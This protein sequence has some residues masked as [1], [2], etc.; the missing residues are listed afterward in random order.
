MNKSKRIKVLQPDG[1]GAAVLEA[2][3]VLT[4]D[5]DCDCQPA[6]PA[7][8]ERVVPSTAAIWKRD[9]R[10]TGLWSKNEAANSW[11]AIRGIGWKKLANTSDSGNI[12]L[13]VLATQA[14]QTG[15]PVDYREEADGMIHEIYVW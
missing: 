9:Q 14:L 7:Q 10:V 1:G 15:R 6:S 8:T 4:P 13:T 2:G 3:P 11:A 12:A 5:A